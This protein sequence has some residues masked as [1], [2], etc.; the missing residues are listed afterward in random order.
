[1]L[2]VVS[3]ANPDLSTKGTSIG[4]QTMLDQSFHAQGRRAVVLI[5][6]TIAK[7]TASQIKKGKSG[8]KKQPHNG[9]FSKSTLMFFL[10][11]LTHFTV[12][13][14]MERAFNEKINEK[15]K[16]SSKINEI[17]YRIDFYKDILKSLYK[18]LEGIKDENDR[19]IFRNILFYLTHELDSTSMNLDY[20]MQEFDKNEDLVTGLFAG[21]KKTKRSNMISHLTKRKETKPESYR[22]AGRDDE[23]L[24]MTQKEGRLASL[25]DQEDLPLLRYPTS[26]NKKNIYKNQDLRNPLYNNSGKTLFSTLSDSNKQKAVLEAFDNLSSV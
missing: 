26:G 20:I 25:K 16:I 19:H 18:V 8:T 15:Y 22:E 23:R 13:E 4:Y 6:P 5:D 10:H 9:E 11:D 24:L 12:Q 3:Y 21:M 1:M 17:S 2:P 14:Q 7:R